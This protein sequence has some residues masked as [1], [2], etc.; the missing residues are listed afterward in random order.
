MGKLE[1]ADGYALMIN[2]RQSVT[3]HHVV[4]TSHACH[5]LGYRTEEY[6]VTLPDGRVV[7]IRTWGWRSSIC[8]LLR[9]NAVASVFNYMRECGTL[10]ELMVRHSCW[11]F[12]KLAD[13]RKAFEETLLKNQDGC[14]KCKVVKRETPYAVESDWDWEK[15]CVKPDTSAYIGDW[16][17]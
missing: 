11:L 15:M 10:K 5:C 16:F 3:F 7:P 4:E 9:N 1:Q 14:A 13:Y 6:P 17:E 12:F 2:C 8:P